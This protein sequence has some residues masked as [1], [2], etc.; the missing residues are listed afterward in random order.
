MVLLISVGCR[1]VDVILGSLRSGY[2][3]YIEFVLEES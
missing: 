2:D 1:I 3:T